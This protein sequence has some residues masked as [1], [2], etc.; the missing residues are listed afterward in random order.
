METESRM[1]DQSLER[2]GDTGSW[3]HHGKVWETD[4]GDGCTTM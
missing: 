2:D 4:S 1:K 3:G